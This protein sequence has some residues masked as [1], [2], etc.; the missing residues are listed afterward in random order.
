MKTL[1][2]LIQFGNTKLPKT[3]VIFNMGPAKTCPSKK[4]GLCELSAKCYA[5]KAERLY[6]QVLPY[7]ECQQ[8]YWI[9]VTAEQFAYEFIQIW[10]SKKIKP[11]HLRFNE[12]GDFHTQDCYNKAEK[13]SQILLQALEIQS[14]TYTHRTDLKYS[15]FNN[16]L[17]LLK[18]G[19]KHN[20]YL[21]ASY[22]AVKTDVYAEKIQLYINQKVYPPTRR[23]NNIYICPGSCKVCA[24]CATVKTGTIYTK[25]H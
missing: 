15:N 25:L 16:A 24:L 17:N 14:Y 9:N 20:D 1:K 12:S 7:R 2:N 23:E 8:E 6:K 19:T 10:R 11:T 21:S 5:L 13:I 4:L 18:S 22:V 3:T